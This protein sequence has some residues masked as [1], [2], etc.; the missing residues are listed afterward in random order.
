M[1]TRTKINSLKKEVS[2]ES[3]IGMLKVICCKTMVSSFHSTVSHILNCSLPCVALKITQVN[4]EIPGT[5]G[6]KKMYR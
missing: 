4:E 5:G 3:C 1:L 2:E 6:P